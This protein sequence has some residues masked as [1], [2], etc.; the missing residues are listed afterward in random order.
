MS[1]HLI[2]ILFIRK[3]GREKGREKKDKGKNKSKQGERNQPG[4]QSD[5][6]SK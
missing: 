6:E 5:M 4:K 2:L 1:Q 3:K